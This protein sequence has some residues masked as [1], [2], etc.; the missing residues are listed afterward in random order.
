MHKEL[1]A[2]SKHVDVIAMANNLARI[3]RAE[4][5]LRPKIILNIRLL[6]RFNAINLRAV[7]LKSDNI[8][9]GIF[10]HRPSLRSSAVAFAQACFDIFLLTH[11][12]MSELGGQIFK[13]T[14]WFP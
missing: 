6:Q 3:R 1:P 14:L 11:Q 7:F 10:R 12:V 9:T 8:F 5:A 4:R 13:T 2:M